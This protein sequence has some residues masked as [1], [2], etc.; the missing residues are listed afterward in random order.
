IVHEYTHGVSIRLLVGGYSTFQA[1]AMGEAWS[2]FYSQEYTLPDGSG[3]DG[4]FAEGPY[5][6]QSW[7]TGI[8]TRPY[9]T[10]LDINALTYADLGHV[11][12]AGREVHADGEIWTE[13][14][15]EV[16]ANLIRQFGEKEGRR[17][18]RMLVLD[19]MKLA[20]PFPTMI[21]MRDGILLADRVDFKGES[22]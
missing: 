9:S 19:G 14:L 17:R 10:N 15:W 5:F 6:N 21:D 22:Q 1:A 13:A 2:D 18:V 16:R 3:A 12:L 7:G 11:I 4:E 20:A 8:R